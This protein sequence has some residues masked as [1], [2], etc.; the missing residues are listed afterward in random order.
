M[1]NILKKMIKT[2]WQNY[3]DKKKRRN[4]NNNNF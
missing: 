3:K 1:K 4:R 2:Y